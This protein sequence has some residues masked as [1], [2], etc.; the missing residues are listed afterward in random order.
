MGTTAG[1]QG[2]HVTAGDRIEV[3]GRPGRPSRRGEVV[4]VLGE[5]G[6]EHLRV[7]WDDGHESVLFGTEGVH[8]VPAAR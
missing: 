4:E 3:S 5:P 2:R 8:V 1:Q 7:R 6:H